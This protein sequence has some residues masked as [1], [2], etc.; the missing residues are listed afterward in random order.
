MA[1]TITVTG[2]TTPIAILK[3][4]RYVATNEVVYFRGTESY[5]TKSNG[6]IDHYG[7]DWDYTT[8]ASNVSTTY[9]VSSHAWTSSGVKTM[10]LRVWNDAGV[11]SASVTQTVT[12]YNGDPVTLTFTDDV[13]RIGMKSTGEEPLFAK[14]LTL[15]GEGGELVFTGKDFVRHTLEG[16]S[17]GYAGMLDVQKLIGYSDS[18]TKLRIYA[19]M[20][21][22]WL[23]GYLTN[24][25]YREQGGEVRIYHWTADFTGESK[26]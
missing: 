6:T 2:S 25:D 7:W 14:N 16:V 13:T 21:K 15:G 8:F 24:F 22:L 23:I 20:D 1:S 17:F 4:P 5:D 19:T 12:V 26:E 10:A 11:S 18:P 3:G 9:D